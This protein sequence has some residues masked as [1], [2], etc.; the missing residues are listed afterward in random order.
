MS[1]FKNITSDMIKEI[2]DSHKPPTH[3]G[4]D[5]ELINTNLLRSPTRPL[6]IVVGIVYD[7]TGADC[8]YEPIF[9]NLT[10]LH[11]TELIAI[12]DTL[13]NMDQDLYN[14]AKNVFTN[15]NFSYNFF[16]YEWRLSNNV[17]LHHFYY[18][19]YDLHV[20]EGK[21]HYSDGFLKP[22]SRP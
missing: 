2:C 7:N 9:N 14:E 16:R 18:E 6:M 5:L 8:E 21:P 12:L 11:P 20:P 3:R 13:Y 10:K 22:N 19:K 15:R 17:N 4:V 1:T